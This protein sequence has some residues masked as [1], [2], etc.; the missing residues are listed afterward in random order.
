MDKW[1]VKAAQSVSNSTVCADMLADVSSKCLESALM[2]LL[3]KFRDLRRVKS[4]NNFWM[5]DQWQFFTHF[6]ILP[7]KPIRH[8]PSINFFNIFACRKTLVAYFAVKDLVSNKRC[9]EPL[10]DW[11]PMLQNI[12]SIEPSPACFCWFSVKSNQTIHFYNKLVCWIT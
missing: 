4:H 3:V 12:F 6:N 1:D 5:T 7:P 10:S 2:L 11:G 9:L 8:K